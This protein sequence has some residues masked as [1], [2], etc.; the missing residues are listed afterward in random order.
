MPTHFIEKFFWKEMRVNRGSVVLPEKT[1]FILKGNDVQKI[2]PCL[3][4]TGLHDV[5]HRPGRQ[6]NE[7]NGDQLQANEV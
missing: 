5:P 1:M 7:R 4:F 2:T 6:R 3:W